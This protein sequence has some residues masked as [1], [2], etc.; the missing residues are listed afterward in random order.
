M[1]ERGLDFVHE[2]EGDYAIAL[3]DENEQR[4]VLVRDRIGV[5]P[6]YYTTR[7]DANLCLRGSSRSFNT[8]PLLRK[9]MRCRCIIT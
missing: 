7:T 9:W 8:L 2:I 4:I 5:K 6:L 3:W 1:K